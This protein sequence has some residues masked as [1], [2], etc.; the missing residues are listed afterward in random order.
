ME[1]NM[2]YSGTDY[3]KLAGDVDDLMEEYLWTNLQE[4]VS[5]PTVVRVDVTVSTGNGRRRRRILGQ[6]KVV[7]RV[8]GEVVYDV[9]KDDCKECRKEEIAMELAHLLSLEILDPQMLMAR[10]E[11][12]HGVTDVGTTFD[13]TRWLATNNNDTNTDTAE[14]TPLDGRG[15]PLERPS[16]LSIIFGFVLTGL[17][18]M[19]LVFYVYLCYKKRQ[20]RLKKERL[21]RQASQFRMPSS[22][23]TP[24]GQPIVAPVIL[25]PPKPPPSIPTTATTRPQDDDQSDVSG[26]RLD[27]MTS[28]GGGAGDAFARE[29]EM[30][31]S[32]DE[33]AWEDFQRKTTALEHSRELQQLGSMSPTPPPPPPPLPPPTDPVMDKTPTSLFGSI[34]DLVW[35]KSFPYGDETRD[36]GIELPANMNGPRRG[37]ALLPMG[38]FPPEEKKD[39]SVGVPRE[40]EA[41]RTT[42][43]NTVPHAMQSIEQV[44]AEYHSNDPKKDRMEDDMDVVSE[45]AKLSRFVERFQKRKE[46]K[47]QFE[48]ERRSQVGT[49]F[50]DV[51][52][53]RHISLDGSISSKDESF[54]QSRPR[55]RQNENRAHIHN[56][57]PGPMPPPSSLNA[58]KPLPS[59]AYRRITMTGEMYTDPIMDTIA[60]PSIS[61]SSSDADSFDE[62]REEEA[63]SRSGR[64]LGITPFSIPTDA[65]PLGYGAGSLSPK[66]GTTV[67]KNAQDEPQR[68]NGRNSTLT[69]S[70]GRVR[71]SALRSN[72]AIIDDSQ[73]DINF[74]A[75]SAAAEEPPSRVPFQN[76]APRP[77]PQPK[78][79]GNPNFNKLRNLFED[80]EQKAIFP[81][82]EYWQSG[83]LS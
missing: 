66:V 29:L 39:D 63:R 51:N 21:Q 24:S 12:V 77:P 35:S 18:A 48:A 2:E 54:Q 25:L 49:T 15:N 61:M 17:A 79:A 53:S 50:S 3:M 62:A 81:P 14:D 75:Q 13:N 58:Q 80:K 45:V 37:R 47:V 34:A 70:G 30:A 10:I 67:T 38:D 7:V 20:K 4:R 82:D 56:M 52:V 8:D 31:A 64:R 41:S 55:R 76:R 83:K 57:R 71:L 9:Y 46:R 16:L 6:P 5:T 72:E 78:T 74:G 69:T 32:L 22:R 36:Q 60:Y 59:T 33:K 1:L 42:A 44:L 11:G 28:D 73:S 65:S 23:I 40:P 26:F 19:G 43:S 27:T 68:L